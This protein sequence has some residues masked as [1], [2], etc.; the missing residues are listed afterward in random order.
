[1][2][3]TEFH[4]INAARTLSSSIEDILTEIPPI[5]VWLVKSVICFNYKQNVLD[6]LAFD[7]YSKDMLSGA[8]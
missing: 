2:S 6:K 5:C 3:Y 1:M 4:I 7:I 8:F